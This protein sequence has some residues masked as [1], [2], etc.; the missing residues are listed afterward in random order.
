M[1]SMDEQFEALADRM[2]AKARERARERVRWAERELAEL[3]ALRE[4][5]ERMVRQ[6]SASE[7]HKA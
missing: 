3:D 4:R 5:V 7:R 2:V 6:Q 1:E